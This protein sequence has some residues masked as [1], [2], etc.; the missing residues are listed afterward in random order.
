MGGG[1]WGGVGGLGGVFE[2]VVGRRGW[3]GGWQPLVGPRTPKRA[4]K[5]ALT[6][7]PRVKPH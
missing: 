3:G 4:H 1:V 5:E 6:L 2:G 7:A